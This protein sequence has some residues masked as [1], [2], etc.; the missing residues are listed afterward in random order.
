MNNCIKN[1]ML[2]ICALFFFFLFCEAAVRIVGKTDIDGNFYFLGRQLYPYRMPIKAVAEKVKKY[3]ELNNSTNIYD[4]VLGWAPRPD[5]SINHGDFE[6]SYNADGIRT[7]H[8]K[9]AVTAGPAEGV[10]R[11]AIFGDSFVQGAE[12]NYA[13]SWG[14]QLERELQKKGVNAEVL[15]FGV[16]GYGIDQ[17]YL[18]Y[19]ECG[20]GF[21]PDIV[22]FGF[23]AENVKRN[24]NL[25]RRF[26]VPETDSIFCKPRFIIT[27]DKL[28]LINVPVP[29]PAMLGY[30]LAHINTWDML[31][32]EKW[33]DESAYKTG[34]L[35]GSRFRSFVQYLLKRSKER[36][37]Y[38]Q[39]EKEYYSLSKEPAMLSLEI[40]RA[41]GEDAEKN[42]SKFITVHLPKKEDIISLSENKALPYGELLKKIEEKYVVVRPE[43]NMLKIKKT[44][45][46]NSLFWNHY[47]VLGNK[48]VA[49]SVSEYITGSFIPE[50]TLKK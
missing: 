46:I 41:F 11:I 25:I 20:A 2:T 26:Y 28:K 3:E 33:Y 21:S 5:H 23:Q 32:Y 37:F 38:E 6:Y 18:R 9:D 29:H 47:T 34:G 31:K 13:D 15:N 40:I 27:G 44:Y 49:R 35:Y 16:N 7:Q 36:L 45:G 22:V 4:T 42:G 17:A 10:L 43:E 30:I 12:V 8:R 1:A 19:K 24:V 50:G 48:A 39:R 14:A